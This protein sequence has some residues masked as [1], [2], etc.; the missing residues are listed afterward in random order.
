M[1]VNFNINNIF[2]DIKSQIKIIGFGAVISGAILFVTLLSSFYADINLLKI[3]MWLSPHPFIIIL[4]V[5][6]LTPY[7]C[8]ETRCDT[9]RI[10]ISS[11][12]LFIISLTAFL[13][14]ISSII[15]II[16]SG[17][18]SIPACN[19]NKGVF[20]VVMILVLMLGLI[21]L[22]MSAYLLWGIRPNVNKVCGGNKC[23]IGTNV[24]RPK[25]SVL[26]FEKVNSDEDEDLESGKYN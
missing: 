10:I 19:N 24:R 15:T 26:R 16:Q 25:N 9:G 13:F 14:I 22:A 7:L 11:I 18:T 23:M 21:E 6:L 2:Q 4:T 1:T 8:S 3:F 12:A 20:I 5:V 17:C